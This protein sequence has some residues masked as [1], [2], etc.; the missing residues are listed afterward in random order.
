MD[1]K[2]Y[3]NKHTN[4][5]RIEAMRKESSLKIEPPEEDKDKPELWKPSHWNWYFD[6][7]PEDNDTSWFNRWETIGKLF[8][9][10]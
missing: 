8:G 2:E 4:R 6:E 9:N 10:S 3:Y 1:P 7:I 5:E